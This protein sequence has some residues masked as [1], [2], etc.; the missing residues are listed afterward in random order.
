[1]KKFVLNSIMVFAIVMV[2]INLV[3]VDGTVKD[4]ELCAKI[5]MYDT[6]DDL[7]KNS[8]LVVIGTKVREEK[9]T[10]VY[11]GD[12]ILYA[13][14]LSDFVVSKALDSKKEVNL[15]NKKI[16]ILENE[17][18]DETQNANY[19][20]AGYNKMLSGESYIL[21]LSYAEENNWYI[22]T[23]VVAGKIPINEKEKSLTTSDREII[24]EVENITKQVK[25]EYNFKELKKEIKVPL[26]R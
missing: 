25:K 19:H 11:D 24:K 16:K 2:V 3:R 5:D 17:F 1:M 26:R 8:D 14:T 4:V 18:Y 13:Y 21:Y 15:E 9:P 22:P 23:G 20:V 7:R 6:L 10:I 12:V